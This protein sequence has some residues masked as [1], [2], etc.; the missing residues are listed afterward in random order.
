MQSDR[1]QITVDQLLSKI[2]QLTIQIDVAESI[3]AS[4][5]KELDD[6]KEKSEKKDSEPGK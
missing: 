4:L 5:Q 6:I 2:G 1:T 3:I